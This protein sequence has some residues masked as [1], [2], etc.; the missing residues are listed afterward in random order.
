MNIRKAEELYQKLE[1]PRGLPQNIF[2]RANARYVLFGVNEPIENIRN[3]RL[4]I[5]LDTG[6]DNLAFSYLSIGCCFAEN[7]RMDKAI[8][9]LEKGARCLEYN[10]FPESNRS[11]YSLYFILISAL[12]YYASNQ[13]S[14]AFI[15]LKE[16][17]TEIETHVGKLTSFFL[18]KDYGKLLN[19]TNQILLD[20]EYI[21][22]ISIAED[23]HIDAKIQ[24]TLFARS[25]SNLIEFL[26]S[27]NQERLT[28]TI[29]ILN[30]LLELLTIENEPS[31]W[32]VVRLFRIIVNGFYESSLWSIIP[33]KL[34]VED[35]NLKNNPL[36]NIFGDMFDDMIPAEQDLLPG[37][38]EATGSK[39][40][41]GGVDHRELIAISFELIAVLHD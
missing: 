16:T 17:E 14:K 32:W 26:Y 12:A 13:Y 36:S 8:V 19:L 6:L 30:D 24:T 21:P 35:S 9:P 15:L 22:S 41:P 40:V 37:F 3:L 38:K 10:H 28:L 5:R 39:R 18:K 27:G 1:F 29:A 34:S 11:N 2:A 7:Q 23:E 31:M 33:P 4:N 20:A 25:L